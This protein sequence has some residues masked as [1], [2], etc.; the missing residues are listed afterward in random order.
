M[1]AGGRSA[2][3]VRHCTAL[4][5][6]RSD[7]RERALVRLLRLRAAAKC[8]D[9]DTF[10]DDFQEVWNAGNAVQGI[11]RLRPGILDIVSGCTDAAAISGLEMLAREPFASDAIAR[12]MQAKVI[13]LK[14]LVNAKAH[15]DKLKQ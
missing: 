6:E 11:E 7:P 1:I 9:F 13:E 5:S 10:V 12:L 3:V 2:H 15:V 8:G 14:A 4:L